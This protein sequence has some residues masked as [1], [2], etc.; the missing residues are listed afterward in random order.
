[1]TADQSARPWLDPDR[2]TTERV[3]LLLAQMTLAEKV[4]QTHQVANIHPDDDAAQLAG[5][6][7]G[8]SLFASGAT[9]G[10][11]RD[12]GVLAANI[13]AAQRHAVEAS[14]LGI[15]VLFGRD[16]IHGHRTVCPIP[17]GL[18]AS[19][20]VG[21]VEEVAAVA[22]AEAV[23][24]GVA[25]TFAPM[26]DLSEEPRWG[27]VAESLGETPVLSGRLAAAMVKGFQ[28]DDP[29]DPDHIAACAKH[30]AGYGLSAGGRDYDTVSVGEN[31]LRNLHLRPFKA[32]VDAGVAT[33]M[34]AFNDV[35]GTPMHAHRHLLRD[36]L[37]G[38]WGFD[39]VVVADWNGIGQLV[40]QGVAADLR[41]AA[42]LAIEAG[43][44]LDMCSGSY[45][46]HLAELV[47]SGEVDE[48]LVDGAVRRLL[49]LK[50]RLGLF[51]R[52]YVG[53]PI[54]SN[55]PTDASRATALRAAHAAH[56]LVSNNGILPLAPGAGTV[57]LT[58]PYAEAAEELF[59]TWTLDGR[60]EDVVAPAT[61]FRARL[62]GEQLLVS[63]G[64][65]SDRSVQQ[66][67][68]AD[69]T[70][71]VVGEHP[72]RS[73][74]ANSVTDIGLPAGQLE[75]LRQLSR[76]GKPLVVVVY[77]GR[78]L[79]LG[80]VL[81]LADAVLVVWHP[82]VEAGNAL[83]DIVFGDVAPHGRLPMTFPRTT[84]HIPTSTHQRP[85]GRLIE[86]HEEGRQGRYLDDQVFPRL[87]FGYGL[88][89]TSFEYGELRTVGGTELSGA[90]E[91]VVEIDVTNTGD[92]AGR[93]V[94]QLSFRDPVAQVTRPLVE[95]VDWAF[96]DLAPGE[97]GTASFTVR[98]D[99]FAYFGTDNTTRVDAGEIVLVA[100]PDAL[101][102]SRLSLRVN[103]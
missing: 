28:G 87:P 40:H 72:W 100:G 33:I 18:A 27:R 36:V 37:K 30:F 41:E 51:D 98:A 56:V 55:A 31:T 17:L 65:F 44:D 62:G 8:S 10:N 76:I 6:R 4:G 95:L 5:G 35:D 93:E 96:L 80:D 69:V 26:V 75:H 84:G 97:K 43:V 61:A 102:G 49:T 23:V 78:P 58:G 77:T 66:V 48:A 20:D 74:E 25:W 79:E 101:H 47:E 70:V 94:V 13:D 60:G 103:P 15:P 85:T 83:A 67:R 64:R 39:G 29:S 99:Q 50:F 68:N 46:A 71:A 19:F 89:Y 92:R 88:T 81:D 21:L 24:D 38:E 7:I 52:P 90:G 86:L 42:L 32:A 9:G 2:S 73:G 57:H 22:A 82:G 12:E 3:E 16:V 59:G 34:A 53:E 11:E 1:M 54:R 45:A 14:R 91:V 63:D